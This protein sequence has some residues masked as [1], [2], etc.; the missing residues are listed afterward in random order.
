[1]TVQA[2]RGFESHPR[3]S[4]EPSRLLVGR[5]TVRFGT[6]TWYRIAPQT[7]FEPVS[8]RTEPL[9]HEVDVPLRRRIRRMPRPGHQRLRRRTAAAAFVIDECRRSCAGNVLPDP[10]PLQRPPYQRRVPRR[11][12]RA[13][14]SPRPRGIP[15][16]HLGSPLDYLSN[17][18]A[19]QSG[20]KRNV[21]AGGSSGGSPRHARQRSRGSSRGRSHSAHV[22]TSS[23]AIARLSSRRASRSDSRNGECVAF[24]KPV[25]QLR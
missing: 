21:S 12:E 4:T 11:V 16:G 5:R 9:T 17:S 10:R 15:Q 19:T 14:G 25:R 1:L 6:G 20:E 24:A 3:R 2:V 18:A 23:A 8:L 7:R 13:T 22:G